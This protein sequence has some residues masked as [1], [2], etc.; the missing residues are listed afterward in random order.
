MAVNLNTLS[1]SL[2]RFD[3]VSDGEFNIGTADSR[4]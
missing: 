2:D 3:A 4:A 1:I